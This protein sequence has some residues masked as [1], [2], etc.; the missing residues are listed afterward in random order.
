[1]H[2]SL[3][4]KPESCGLACGAHVTNYN[5][6]FLSKCEITQLAE[7]RVNQKEIAKSIKKII[8]P[9]ALFLMQSCKP[10]MIPLN[11]N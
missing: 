3:Y 10:N 2:L 1:M 7:L 6:M 9:Q 5:S 4:R 8:N 11:C